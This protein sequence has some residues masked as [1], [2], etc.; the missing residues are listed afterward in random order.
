MEVGEVIKCRALNRNE[1]YMDEGTNRVHAKLCKISSW[2]DRMETYC[3]H[4]RKHEASGE[5][6][7]LC[8]CEGGLTTT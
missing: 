4:A 6:M 5:R 3:A 8:Q 1:G 7:R 2:A